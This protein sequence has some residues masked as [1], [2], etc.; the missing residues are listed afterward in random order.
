M[1]LKLNATNGGGSVELDV[2]NTVSSDVVLTLP[3]AD[4]DADQVLQTNGSGT[5]SWVA[6]GTINQIFQ[7]VETSEV[8]VNTT[9]YTDLSL[10]QAI[11]PTSTSSKILVMANVKATAGAA[12]EGYGLQIRQDIGGT[13][14]NIYSAQQS[15]SGGPFDYGAGGQLNTKA[16][17]L[18][19]DEPNTTSEVT[20]SI[21]G[22]RNGSSAAFFHPNT[23]TTG[24]SQL[25]VMEIGA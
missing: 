3:D 5:L 23:T 25:I 1:G 24:R 20:Y 12:G 6:K 19:L 17:L 4:G 22:A 16:T 2:P 14:T 10:S 21:F 13:V 11:T 18:F 8:S 9:T 15:S 7:N